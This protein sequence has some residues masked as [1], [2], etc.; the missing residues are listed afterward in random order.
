VG[1]GLEYAAGAAKKLDLSRLR[2]ASH[3]VKP[4]D[5]RRF[6]ARLGRSVGREDYFH[7]DLHRAR[8]E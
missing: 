7:L 6:E 3:L 4:A 8:A 2:V 5:R 1:D